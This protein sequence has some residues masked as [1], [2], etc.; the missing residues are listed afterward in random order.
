MRADVWTSRT[1]KWD[2]ARRR[3]GRLAERLS[4]ST[5]RHHRQLR[6]RSLPLATLAVPRSPRA[7]TALRSLSLACRAHQLLSC[8]RRRG[9]DAS[10][11]RTF[12]WPVR[13][14]WAP[15]CEERP[16]AGSGL[17]G[18]LCARLC[19]QP[20]HQAR[21]FQ[22][23]PTSKHSCLRASRHLCVPRVAITLVFSVCQHST[24]HSTTGSPATGGECQPAVK[25]SVSVEAI[26]NNDT[27]GL[28]PH[29]DCK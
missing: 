9:D 15:V 4:K 7:W 24:Q 6:N 18:Q 2:Q 25:R 27:G 1:L 21:F 26:G 11:V 29:W 20:D 5:V 16:H 13:K 17:D 28:L 12:P 8:A 10:R 14:A 22:P 23:L 19:G 3:R